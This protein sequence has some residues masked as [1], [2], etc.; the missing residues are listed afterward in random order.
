M[1]GVIEVSPFLTTA[2]CCL[3]MRFI[4]SVAEKNVVENLAT[5]P[6]L[7]GGADCFCSR[8]CCG[9]GTKND[10]RFADN[11]FSASKNLLWLELIV[12]NIIKVS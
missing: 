1:D 3:V 6:V 12:M 10:Y 4:G 2:L 9:G 11:F 8:E 5:S 7:A